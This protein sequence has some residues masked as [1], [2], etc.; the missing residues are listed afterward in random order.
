M[1]FKGDFIKI[2][3]LDIAPLKQAIKAITEEEWGASSWRQETFEAH[4]DT[5]T[6]E[7]VFDADF[8]HENPTYLPKYFEFEHL[9]KPITQT[10]ARY[11]NQSL[12]AKRLRK[13][14]GEGY[15]VRM[16]LV[17][18]VPGGVISPHGDQG[19]SLLHG[20]RIHVP[21]VSQGSTVFNVA[22]SA[23]KLFEGE[24]WEINNKRTHSVVNSGDSARIHLISDWVLPG[25]RCCCG[26][27][28]RPQ[29]GCSV[30]EC[31]V[32]D[33]TAVVCSCYPH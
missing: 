20:H 15:L 16:I 14:Y 29:G 27:K 1:N 17:R 26:K 2:G 11:Y 13:K 24:I 18:L 28:Q 22:N 33:H 9:L 23:K 31:R 7:L 30:E 3:A 5:Q 4:V 32:T 19:Y 8:R 21:I 25:E 10:F 6:I 12:T